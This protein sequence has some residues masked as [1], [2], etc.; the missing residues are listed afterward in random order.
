M[1]LPPDSSNKNTPRIE[2]LKHRWG[3]LGSNAYSFDFNGETYEWRDVTG[4]RPKVRRL[5]RLAPES[6]ASTEIG[7]AGANE[8]SQTHDATEDREPLRASIPGKDTDMVT[9]TWTEGA[10]PDRFGKIGVFRASASEELGSYWTLLAVTS[11]LAVCQQG[12]AI[13]GTMSW[14]QEKMLETGYQPGATPTDRAATWKPHEI[15]FRAKDDPMMGK[16]SHSI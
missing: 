6:K 9:A 4:S 8:R 3:G 1:T 10:V 11:A 14:H 16:V 2:H 5:I 7:Q 12:T 13:D 15:K